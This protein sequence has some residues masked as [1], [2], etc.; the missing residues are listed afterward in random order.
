MLV[1]PHLLLRFDEAARHVVLI[2]VRGDQARAFA[3]DLRIEGELLCLVTQCV[4][5]FAARRK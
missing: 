5:E 3:D 4:A 2:L 1:L